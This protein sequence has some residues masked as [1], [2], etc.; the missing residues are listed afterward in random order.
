MKNWIIALGGFLFLAIIAVG[1]SYGNLSN[2]I[3]SARSEI[4]ALRSDVQNLQVGGQ[5]AA[6]TTNPRISMIDLITEIQPI[7]VRVDV[8]GPGFQASGSGV[9]FRSD[10]HIITNAHVV[11]AADGIQVTLST[12]EQH[13]A[14]VV[15]SD[16]NLD[17]A[18]IKL[19]DVPSN[20]PS[21]V[22]GSASDIVTGGVAVAAGFPLGPSL[23]GPAS[24]TQ[25]I[26]SA[27]R[28]VNGQRYIQ[29]DVQINPGNSGGALLD[30][31][32]GKV[33]GVTTAG[34][35]LSG[36]DI[37]GIGLAIPI[38]VIQTY[39]QNSLGQ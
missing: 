3:N 4:A 24:F 5:P 25:G 30:R 1:V 27:I 26:V 18:I 13:S 10:G 32:T 21:A 36:Q 6:T 22:L 29:T 39:I 37:E 14:T 7:I 31:S 23:P 20:L 15:S 8:T 2:E 17:L 38:D 11:E 34:V 33:I 16:S 28:I 19:T 12:E 35:I 9:I